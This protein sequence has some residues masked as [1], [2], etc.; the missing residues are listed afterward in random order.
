MGVRFFAGGVGADVED[1]ADAGVK[2]GPAEAELAEAGLAEAFTSIR[3]PHLGQTIFHS[4]FHLGQDKAL[5]FVKSPARHLLPFSYYILAIKE[6]QGESYP[7]N[8]S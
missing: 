5:L 8:L 2:A 4:S 3:T 1:G 7:E 6:S